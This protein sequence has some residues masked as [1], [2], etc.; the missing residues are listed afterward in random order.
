METELKTFLNIFELLGLQYFSLRELTV[1]NLKKRPTFLRAIFMLILVTIVCSLMIFVVNSDNP[2]VEGKVTAKNVVMFAIKR[3]FNLGMILVCCS[4]I[5]QSFVSTKKIKKVF[6]NIRQVVKIVQSEFDV[7]VDF[8]R[9]KISALKKLWF[10][11]IFFATIHASVTL[12]YWNEENL[13]IRTFLGAIPVV[14]LLIVVYKILFFIALINYQ[15]EL[16]S[17]IV[18]DIFQYHPI[19][20]I[21]NINFHLTSVKTVEDPLEKLRSARKIFNIIFE[22][23]ALINSSNGFTILIML[24]TLV[25]SL[26][27]S[28]YEVFIIIVGGLP[29][30]NIPS[31]IYGTILTFSILISTVNHCQQTAQ[32]VSFL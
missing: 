28:G 25:I 12:V 30:K 9:F 31:V 24:I 17:E 1:D 2:E 18:K 19:K 29:I 20:I 6:M 10:L 11:L 14:F 13:F 4:S 5:V 8:K 27:V 21:E 32:I 16:L 15:L 23:G 26:T 22:S 7:C 3:S